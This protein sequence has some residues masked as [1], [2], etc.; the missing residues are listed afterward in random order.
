MR[1]VTSINASIDWTNKESARA[2]LKVMMKRTLRHFGYPL[3]MELLVT[4]TVL[5][6]AALVT[7]ELTRRNTRPIVV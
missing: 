5:K 4:E 7:T 1:G 3:D 2:K 6:Q